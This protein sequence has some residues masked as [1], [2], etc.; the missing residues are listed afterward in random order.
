MSLDTASSPAGL[1]P[2][3]VRTGRHHV[4]AQP[5]SDAGT[6]RCHPIEPLDSQSG[7]EAFGAS[8]SGLRAVFWG[9]LW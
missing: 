4:L 9:W 8:Q 1:T 2:T 3:D 6:D 7:P 5:S